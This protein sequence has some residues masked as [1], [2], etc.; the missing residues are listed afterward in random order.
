MKASAEGFF[1]AG[2]RRKRV[3]IKAESFLKDKRFLDFFLERLTEPR[4]SGRPRER[5][6]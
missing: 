2:F 1:Y 6:G 4:G 3:A 5:S